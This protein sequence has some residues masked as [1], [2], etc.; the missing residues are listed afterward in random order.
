MKSVASATSRSNPGKLVALIDSF[1]GVNLVE[2]VLPPLA[3]VW[4]RQEDY[5]GRILCQI[6]SSLT[7]MSRELEA[8]AKVVAAADAIANA[9]FRTWR[10]CRPKDD[11]RM[12][13]QRLADL[14]AQPRFTDVDRDSG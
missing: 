2:I 6:E 4:L 14:D 1:P 3:Q 11:A 13:G 12:N 5:L 10:R 9:R 8:D 7:V